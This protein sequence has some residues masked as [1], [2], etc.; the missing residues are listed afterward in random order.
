MVGSENIP[1]TGGCIIAPNHVSYLDPPVAGASVGRHVVFM[2]FEGLYHYPSLKYW[3]RHMGCI[4]V[5]RGTG[6]R[7]ALM[8]AVSQLKLGKCV[9]IFPEGKRVPPGQTGE[10]QSGIALMAEMADVPVVPM[11]ITGTQPWYRNYF[12]F[13]PWFSKINVRIGKPIF[14]ERRSTTESRSEL[15]KRFS[16]KILNEIRRL[17][18]DVA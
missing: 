15:H 18:A 17:K 7:K 14:G 1:K 8:E 16:E 11:A 10:A 6:N 12:G 2:A 3:I 4:P 13:L 9:C 5:F